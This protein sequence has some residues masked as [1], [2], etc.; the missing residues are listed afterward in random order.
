MAWCIGSPASTRR[1]L[2]RMTPR[3]SASW[4]AADRPRARFSGPVGHGGAGLDMP[5]A[6]GSATSAPDTA[7]RNRLCACEPQALTCGVCRMTRHTCPRFAPSPL[8][9]A[10]TVARAAHADIVFLA[11]GYLDVPVALAGLPDWDGR[12]LVD[13]TNQFQ[14]IDGQY[15]P[16]DLGEQTGSEVIAGRRSKQALRSSGP[17]TPST[18]P[19]SSPIL[20]TTPAARWSSTRVTIPTPRPPFTVS[21]TSSVSPQSMSATYTVVASSCKSTAAHSQPCISSNRTE[22]RA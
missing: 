20:A 22:H 1:G 8:A 12:I 21:S 19:T 14:L 6:T 15:T 7:K 3:W 17:S 13:T 4:A 11:V 10:G 2:S 18:P 5:N 16:L 9:S